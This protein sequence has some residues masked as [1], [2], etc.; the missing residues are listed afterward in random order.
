MFH[1]IESDMYFGDYPEERVFKIEN[2]EIHQSLGKGIRTVEFIYHDNNDSLMFIEAKHSSPRKETS[3]ERYNEWINEITDKFI[4]SFNMYLASKFK[5][6]SEFP[7]S[8][9]KISDENITY[10]FVLVINGHESR[11]LPPLREE[12]KRKM[13]Y[14]QKIWKSDV[15]VY[16]DE[17]A[18]KKGLIRK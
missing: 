7:G 9:G 17:L 3:V 5:R 11:W 14:N 12:L 1:V 4:H 18:Y 8:I 2:S 16:N 13:K 15:Q 10:K 6:I